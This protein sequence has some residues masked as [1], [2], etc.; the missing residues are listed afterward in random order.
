MVLK[1]NV[2]VFQPYKAKH[3]TSLYVAI[4]HSFQ[5]QMAIEM[6]AN[7]PLI[8]VGSCVGFVQYDYRSL[9]ALPN[10]FHLSFAVFRIIN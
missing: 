7:N 6:P 3:N 5:W 8:C 10:K 1:F 2:Q 9:L 4:L